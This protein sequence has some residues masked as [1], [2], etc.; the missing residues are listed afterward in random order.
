M[1]VTHPYIWGARGVGHGN[2]Y[3]LESHQD[4]Y[5]NMAKLLAMTAI[6]LLGD[7]AGE[8][9]SILRDAR[10]RLTKEEY[11]AFNRDMHA[12][13]RFDERLDDASG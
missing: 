13:V 11:L 10:P 4:V 12:T 8:A 6:D 3:I 5:V 1:P 2:D 7:E 9:R